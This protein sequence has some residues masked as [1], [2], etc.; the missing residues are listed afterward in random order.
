[1]KIT[2]NTGNN[3]SLSYG[4]VRHVDAQNLPGTKK[5][6]GELIRV[7]PIRNTGSVIVRMFKA[8]RKL[9]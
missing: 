4:R 1:M 9:N 2:Q 8:Y 6:A 3:D 5:N 7:S